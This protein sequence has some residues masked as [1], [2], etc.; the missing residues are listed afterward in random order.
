MKIYTSYF[1]RQRKMELEDAS[2]VSIAVGNPKYPVPYKI[3]NLKA[4]KPYGIFGVGAYNEDEYR[5]KYFA[6]LDRY[7]VD[8]IRKEIIKAGEGHENVILMCHEK[9]KNECHRKM[10]ADWWEKNTG[11]K[12]EEYGESKTESG[13]KE[14]VVYEQLSLF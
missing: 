9:D 5:E 4:L 10:F 7:G 1:A 11:E 8:Y 12:I 2:Y 14:K 6:R 3:V 13:E